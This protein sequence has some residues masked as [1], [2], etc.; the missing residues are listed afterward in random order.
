MNILFMLYE[1]LTLFI[2]VLITY[3]VLTCYAKRLDLCN[4]CK[5]FLKIIIFALYIDMVLI[6]TGSGTIYEIGKYDEIIRLDEITLN[7]FDSDGVATYI[8]NIIMCI[9]FGFLIP[10]IWPKSRLGETALSGLFFSFMIETSQLLN[11]RNSA[12][13]DLLMNTI[14]VI[15]GYLIYVL[16]CRLFKSLLDREPKNAFSRFLRQ[17]PQ[18]LKYE[19]LIYLVGMFIGHF[20]LYNWRGWI[21]LFYNYYYY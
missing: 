12:V 1:F 8:L 7:L 15:L 4:P 5:K 14:G 9:P 20:F 18:L 3:F 16:F 19:Y 13:D 11:R 2:L 6:V 17:E 10:L 21:K